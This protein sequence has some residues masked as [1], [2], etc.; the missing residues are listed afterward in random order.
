MDDEVDDCKK[1]A[2]GVVVEDMGLAG[3]GLLRGYAG[4]YGQVSA[5][6]V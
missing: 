5:H 4:C 1:E 3:E 2:D 6:V